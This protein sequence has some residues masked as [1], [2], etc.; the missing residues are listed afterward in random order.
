[1]VVQVQCTHCHA[2]L[3]AEKAEPGQRLRCGE[4]GRV[5][6]VPRPESAQQDSVVDR[7]AAA[8]EAI[9]SGGAD[10]PTISQDTGAPAQQD[11]QIAAPA[12]HLAAEP[13]T[14][15][16]AAPELP[17]QAASA[18]PATMTQP[19]LPELPVAP[20]D[21]QQSSTEELHPV[22][23]EPSSVRRRV[24]NA[25]QKVSLPPP[26]IRPLT[27]PDTRGE[28]EL[29]VT[30]VPDAPA[31]M[32][33][34]MPEPP[35]RLYTLESPYEQAWRRQFR[36]RDLP[37]ETWVALPCGIVA[38]LGL[39]F[40]PLALPAV[41]IVAVA[42]FIVHTIGAVGIVARA[43]WEGARCGVMSIF[44]P[45]YTIYFIITRFDRVERQFWRAV[46]GLGLM[47]VAALVFA[48]KLAGQLNAGA[49]P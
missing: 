15:T 33:Q 40:D 47:L 25:D 48:A 35:G 4:C 18:E 22:P 34:N 3:A 29:L 16:P 46:A 23:I 21:A 37:G 39:I 36:L 42:G 19:A 2:L 13:P 8:L 28:D 49:S 17:A 10:A 26:E 1:M 31:T 20:P 12:G 38:V 30:E 32:E 5:F 9:A 43:F 6:R 7:A 11:T 27:V 24:W 44:L 45:P 41:V 14:I